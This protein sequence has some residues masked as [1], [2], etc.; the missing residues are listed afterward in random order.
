MLNSTFICLFYL[1]IYVVL[2]FIFHFLSL[3]IV[4][5]FIKGNDRIYYIFNY[6]LT[7]SIVNES[8]V[9]FVWS[10]YEYVNLMI[11]I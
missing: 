9:E 11:D 1:F 5:I 7:I 10:P 4:I 8:I 2:C 6:L 3:I